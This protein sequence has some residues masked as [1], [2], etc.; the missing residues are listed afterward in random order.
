M[1]AARGD[2]KARLEIATGAGGRTRLQVFCQMPI[3]T[4]VSVRE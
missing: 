2:R 4:C 3:A 1:V